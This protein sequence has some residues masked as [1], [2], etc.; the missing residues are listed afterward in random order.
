MAYAALVSFAQIMEQIIHHDDQDSTFLHSK[1]QIKSLHDHI[2]FL[3]AFLEDFPEKSANSLKGR[4]RDTTYEAENIIEYFMSEQVRSNYDSG[5]LYEELQKSATEVDLIEGEVM[6]IKN[7]VRTGDVQLMSDFP[8]ASSSSRKV[9]TPTD[10]DTMVGFNDDLMIIKTPLCGESSELKVVPIFGMGGI[11]KTTL[12]RNAYEDPL[13]VEHFHIRVWVTVSQDYST[14]AILS[15]LQVSIKAFN[16]EHE[17]RNELMDEYVHKSL[18]GRTY[19]IVM[20]DMW[21]TGAWDDVMR[22]LPNDRNGSRIMLTTRLSDVAVYAASSSPL[23]RMQFMDANQ[24]WK[25]LCQKV[26]KQEHCPRELEDIGRMI[27]RSCR[28]LPPAIVV[29]AGL[30]STGSK[31]RASWKN[32]AKN[33]NLVVTTHDEHFAKILSLSYTHLPHHL[34]PCSLYVGGFPKDYHIRVSKLIKLWAAEGFLKLSGSKNYEE[35]AE[36]YLE[37]LVKRSLVMVTKRKPNG[38][39]KSCSLHDLLR[40]MCIKKAQEEKFLQVMDKYVDNNLLKSIE[41]QRRISIHYVDLL[42]NIHRTGTIRTIIYFLYDLSSPRFIQ[43]FRLLRVLDFVNT[44]FRNFPTEVLELFQLRYLALDCDSVNIPPSIS[45]LQNLQ[46]LIINSKRTSMSVQ[47]TTHFPS[48]F[49]KM[50]QLRHVVLFRLLALPNLL[51]PTSALKNLQTLLAV[52]NFKCTVGVLKMIPNL[53]K[54]GIYIHSSGFSWENYHLNNLVHLHQLEK[55]KLVIRGGI[56]PQNLNL[57]FSTTLKKLSLNWCLL[58]SEDMAVFG[59]LPNLE[60]LKLRNHACHGFKWETN[61]G[62]FPRLKFLLIKDSDLQ[63]WITESSHFPNLKCLVLHSCNKLRKIP[64]DIGE[65]PTLEVIE[66]DNSNI[67]LVESAKRIKEEQQ[68]Y[69]NDAFQ[70]RIKNRHSYV[71]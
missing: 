13:I 17:Q 57:A 40:D 15:N 56:H 33:V 65:I 11:G 52:T 30:L 41:K 48:E 66:V 21:S 29:I 18:K 36:E 62:Q 59:A 45:N 4:I 67:S 20:D 22:V 16:K 50:T 28:G 14:Q 43:S 64:D 8:N 71:F 9:L 69:G 49:W 34:R 26:F 46:T 53:K 61:E 5:K 63:H 19:V 51:G 54:L 38:T 27:A 35:T 6:E 2:I 44:C 68:N 32:I 70:V 24:S 37:D 47:H 60:V 3:Q 58:A 39:I 42:A 23:H 12:A 55:F 31:S 25:L 10:E 1:Q 7:S